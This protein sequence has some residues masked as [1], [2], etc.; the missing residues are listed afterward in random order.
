MA[1]Q[2]SDESDDHQEG[3]ADMSLDQQDGDES[4]TSK[5]ASQSGSSR[6]RK[7]G[8]KRSREEDESVVSRAPK[9]KNR[10]VAAEKRAK[11]WTN[12]VGEKF[13]LNDE[14]KEVKL[15]EVKEWK[16]KY[17]MVSSLYAFKNTLIVW[18]PPD[19]RH[20]DKDLKELVAVERWVDEE[21]FDRLKKASMLAWQPASD[22][23]APKS[24]SD[25]ASMS[26][27]ES[28]VC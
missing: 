13:M 15:V 20:P 27:T 3:Q 18:Q 22:S 11:E 4:R 19:S 21:E 10:K 23:K 16:L 7:K 14:G 17:Q 26:A 9:K 12:L 8:K 25:D 24:G 6:K 1:E 2:G 28:E 5:S